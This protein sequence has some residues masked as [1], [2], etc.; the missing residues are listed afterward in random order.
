MT[1][2]SVMDLSNASCWTPAQ[3]LPA[4]VPKAAPAHF[5]G[6][7]LR[8]A[9]L[10]HFLS[11]RGN[12]RPG[13]A[14]VSSEGVSPLT[15]AVEPTERSASGAV[16]RL[17]EGLQEGDVLIPLV[18][19]GPCVLVEARHKSLAFSRKF[20]AVRPAVPQHGA[21][22]WALLSSRTGVR[23]R[24]RLHERG[25]VRRI[26]AT[27]LADLLIPSPETWRAAPTALLPR[28]P[29]NRS[30][31]QLFL[32]AWD[33]LDLREEPDWSPGW[34]LDPIH[35][36][37]VALSELGTARVGRLDPRCFQQLPFAA[38]VPAFRS[39]DVGRLLVPR[40]WCLAENRDIAGPSTLLVSSVSLRVSLVVEPVAFARDIIAID[41]REDTLLS[42]AELGRRLVEY[43]SSSIGQRRLR[44]SAGGAT[45][46]RLTKSSLLQ[47]AV[48]RPENLPAVEP[49]EG[50]TLA[51]RLEA[52]LWS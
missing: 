36:Y 40:W 11:P 44:E 8:L 14:L 16:F 42:A 4:P 17:G 9:E 18:G 38:S 27:S 26:D 21:Y 2:W 49:H 52:A 28:E 12:S 5:G 10:V 15:G 41:W 19:A 25:D 6:S 1:A 50:E 45:I 30:A 13:E 20:S 47:V 34:L 46:A 35:R 31:A 22:L 37:G 51:S 24:A 39:A 29:V 33:T 48:P 32:G 3:L 7:F 23:A 43:L